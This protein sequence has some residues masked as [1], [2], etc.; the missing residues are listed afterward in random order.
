L[1]AFA[2]HRR[3]LVRSTLLTVAILDILLLAS[4]TVP[5][6]GFD[7]RDGVRPT[8][9]PG[10]DGGEPVQPISPVADWAPVT[11]PAPPRPAGVDLLVVVDNSAGMAGAQARL[12]SALGALLPALDKLGGWRLGMITTD[13]GVGPYTT[14]TCGASGQQGALQ[15]PQGC[16]MISP[17]D[18]FLESQGGKTNFTGSATAAAACLVKAGSSGCGFEQPLEALR[19]ALKGK[20]SDLL[21]PTA[22]LAVI[23]LTAD[24][25]CSVKDDAL[26]DWQSD[27]YGPYALYRCFQHGV[28]CNGQEPPLATGTLSN[29]QPGG[30]ALNDPQSYASLLAGLRPAGWVSTLVIAAPTQEPLQVVGGYDSYGY[31]YWKLKPACQTS[32]LAGLPAVRLRA[33]RQGLG[34]GGLAG[35]ICATSYQPVIDQLLARIK[36]VF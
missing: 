15:V 2:L 28:R 29:C 24:D 31:Y 26:F 3:G 20:A 14:Q 36:A 34:A 18:R 27:E 9:V 13:L 16:G 23:V 19:L 5:N 11:P 6:P 21:R 17:G 30:T 4:C 7:P 33:F 1:L 32:E 35:D 22:A 10:A 12:G 25:D 8:V